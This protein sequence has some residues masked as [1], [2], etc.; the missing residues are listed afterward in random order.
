PRPR[1]G[2]AGAQEAQDP[3]RRQEGRAPA[4]D[5]QREP[6]RADLLRV[7]PEEGRR[8]LRRRQLQGAVRVYR[9]GPDAPRRIKDPMNKLPP[10]VDWMRENN[11]DAITRELVF[12]DF[13]RAFAFM[14]HAALAAEKADHQP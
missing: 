1:R 7:H 4:A 3:G 8:R 11:R 12:P 2:L 6:A 13:N 9:A 10:P 5:L 14:T